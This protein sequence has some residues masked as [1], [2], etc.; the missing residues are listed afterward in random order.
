MIIGYVNERYE[1]VIPIA[2]PDIHT[3]ELHHFTA[4]IDTGFDHYLMLPR[5]TI[6]RLGY[7]ITETRGMALANDQ[8]HEF[9]ESTLAILWD[10][11]PIPIPVLAS[12]Y[13]QILVGAH[14]LA[15]YYLTVAMV[16]GG[17]VTLT[18]LP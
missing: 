10:D 2:L 7:P 14:L 6:T 5:T 16:P 12:E 9:G 3:R 15:G 11:E 18:R 4:V 13:E 8:R 17:R 1:A